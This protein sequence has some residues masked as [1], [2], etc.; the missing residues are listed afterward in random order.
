MSVVGDST[1]DLFTYEPPPN[2]LL[3][4]RGRHC[5]GCAKTN[6]YLIQNCRDAPRRVFENRTIPLPATDPARN[7]FPELVPDGKGGK[8][9]NPKLEQYGIQFNPDGTEPCCSTSVGRSPGVYI[10]SNTRG[11]EGSFLQQD[12]LR[13]RSP[14]LTDPNLSELLH[15]GKPTGPKPDVNWLS[16]GSRVYAPQGGVKPKEE[17]PRYPGIL[18]GVEA[19]DA[20]YVYIEYTSSFNRLLAD[21]AKFHITFPKNK[22]ADPYELIEI[23]NILLTLIASIRAKRSL[24]D[25]DQQFPLSSDPSER[26]RIV[27]YLKQVKKMINRIIGELLKLQDVKNLINVYPKIY[28]DQD[29][30]DELKRILMLLQE[31]ERTWE[32]YLG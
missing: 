8:K 32:E 18:S 10:P 2:P 7:S 9:P 23:L 5:F 15:R 21:L 31:S 28:K 3:C 12:V 11:A 27:D 30:I 17:K 29:A 16:G 19:Q 20:T 1:K 4:R 6:S 25:E 24:F 13:S 26:R 14:L 22:D